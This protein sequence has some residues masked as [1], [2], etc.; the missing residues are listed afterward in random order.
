MGFYKEQILPRFQDK[1]MGAKRLDE[2]RQRVCEGLE[3][4]VVEIGLGTGLN[5]PFYPSSVTRL[6]AIEP[7]R[8]CMR[9]A[10]PR[11]AN[12]TVPFEFGGLTGERLDLPSGEFD[13]VLSTW[14]LCTIP[15][16]DAALAE[17]RRVL[18]PDGSFHFIE[19]GHSPDEKVARL[20][21][22]FEPMNKRLGGGCHLTRHI[23]K[24]IEKAG[25]DIEKIE[26]YYFKR[27][28]KPIGYT[29]EGRAVSR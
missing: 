1:V 18:K 24:D 17:I 13:A 4:A 23:S 20:Q 11:L 6:V 12:A 10:E 28:P 7:S 19:H 5:A 15:N 29:Y 3:G 21:Q 27:E 26:T 22:R 8:V 2:A 9:I 25:F 14:T 16:L